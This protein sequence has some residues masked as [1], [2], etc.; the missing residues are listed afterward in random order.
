MEKIIAKCLGLGYI[1]IY[2]Q[3][4]EGIG[5]KIGKREGAKIVIVGEEKNKWVLG[6]PYQ[7]SSRLELF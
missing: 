4:V 7:N 6:F 1:Y 2:R 5:K 3:R